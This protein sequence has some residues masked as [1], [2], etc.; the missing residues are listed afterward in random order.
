MKKAVLGY[1]SF[2]I[3]IFA[4]VALIP[5]KIITFERYI[6]NII[7][8]ILIIS[9]LLYLFKNLYEKVLIGVS[10]NKTLGLLGFSLFLHGLA[11][12]YILGFIDKPNFP[13]SAEGTSFLLMNNYFLYAKPL[14]IFIQQLIIIMLVYKFNELGMSLKKIIS[15]FVFSFGLIHIFQ[16]F[17]TDMI[18]GIGFTFF[19]II[20]SFIFPYMIL[21]VK[22]GAIYDFMI[23]LGVYDIVAV[24]IYLLY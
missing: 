20:A 17:K 6:L 15:I 4:L 3:I 14:E 11:C 8:F 12:F 9:L 1:L 13:F 24:L 16:I 5:S 19:A 18:I 22:N 21:K 10:I 2:F 23:H 7:F